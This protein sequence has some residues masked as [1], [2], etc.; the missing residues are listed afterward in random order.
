MSEPVEA[1][2][3]HA[4]GGIASGMLSLFGVATGLHPMLLA[5]GMI[6]GWWELSHLPDMSGL[7]RAKTI[8]VSGFVGA[9]SSPVIAI[10]LT[11]FPWWPAPLA[12]DTACFP[13]SVAAG[14]VTYIF[15]TPSAISSGFGSVVDFIKGYLPRGGGQ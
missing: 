4:G 8:V 5:A 2:A 7:Q 12:M 11:S 9:W 3:V 10:G 14:F 13:I 15:L 1:I 6:G